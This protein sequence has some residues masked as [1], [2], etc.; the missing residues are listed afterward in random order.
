MYG[1]ATA[2]QPQSAQRPRRN[3]K[4]LRTPR[5]LRYN[6]RQPFTGD[7][8]A[9]G[10]KNENPAP[11]GAGSV[12]TWFHP[13]SASRDTFYQPPS[14][15][16]TGLPGAPYSRRHAI[17]DT[18][19]AICD[20]RYAM[21]D[22]RSP[23]SRYAMCDT[24][25]PISGARSRGVFPAVR[26]GRLP[27]CDLPSLG[28]SQAGTRPGPR[29]AI[30]GLVK[31]YPVLVGCQVYIGWACRHGLA[32]QFAL[33][34]KGGCGVVGAAKPPPQPHFLLTSRARCSPKGIRCT[35]SR[36]PARPRTRTHQL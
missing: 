9:G 13:G 29:V 27:A 32:Q 25:S 14:E 16:V 15:A 12:P 36:T 8:P 30:I 33:H 4:T 10:E 19:Y 17:C 7:R 26:S 35:S 31:L 24:R 1:A 2:F 34:G 18:R 11:W 5:S 28:P 6:T 22:T 20:T 21:C 23:I 3:R